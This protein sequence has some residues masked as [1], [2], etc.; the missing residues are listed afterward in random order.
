MPGVLK[1]KQYHSKKWKHIFFFQYIWLS[2]HQF[3]WHSFGWDMWATLGHFPCYFC[4]LLW[5]TN[6]LDIPFNQWGLQLSSAISLPISTS[7]HTALSSVSLQL[8]TNDLPTANGW[9]QK[10]IILTVTYFLFICFT[11][12][13]SVGGYF[14]ALLLVIKHWTFQTQIKSFKVHFTSW[15]F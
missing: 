8:P 10:V 12:L 14:Y 9:M 2:I 15:L 5:Q 11:S 7:L 1:M 6:G 3:S 13:Q 4:P